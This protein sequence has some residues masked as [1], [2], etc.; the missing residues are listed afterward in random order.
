MKARRFVSHEPR[1]LTLEEVDLGPVPRDGVLVEN[2]YTAVSVGTEIYNWIHGAEPGNKPAFPRT[3]GYCNSGTVLEVGKD[4]TS[5]EPGDRVAG[6]GRHASHDIL[7]RR[8]FKVPPGVPAKA[9]PLL[10][11]AAIAQHGNRVARVELGESVVVIGLG[12][13]G[14]LALTLVRLSGGRPVVA[15]DV[16]DFRLER[17]RIRGADLCIN[18]TRVADVAAAVREACV[19]DGANVVMECTGRPEVYPMA[20]RLSSTAGRMVALGSPR[21]K[22]EMDFFADMHL[23]EVRLVGAMQPRTPE[24]DHVYYRWS[25]QRERTMLLQLMAE[26]SLVVDDLVTHVV[27]PPQ[28]REIYAMLA[29]RPRQVLGVLFDWRERLAAH[30]LGK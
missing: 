29:D 3:T 27:R 8:Y 26:G 18:P 6:E 25:K 17:A 1:H 11:M 20:V 4:V 14:Q 16:D 30:G 7:T 12:L 9:A 22:V 21:G 24:Q 10:T 23:R 19:D 13:V 15:I 5:V 28:C 2:R